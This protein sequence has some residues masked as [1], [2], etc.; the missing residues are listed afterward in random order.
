MDTAVGGQGAPLVP[1][2]DYLRYS[3]PEKSRIILNLGGIAN[4]TYLPSSG[5][6]NEVRAFDVGPANILIDGAVRELY[7]GR[8]TR[9]EG[10]A[11]ARKGQ[12]SQA[13]FEYILKLDD[14]RFLPFPKSTGRERYSKSFLN[15]V[16]DHG[17]KKLRL[18]R[19]DIIATISNYS[20]FMIEYHV[21]KILKDPKNQKVELIVGGGGSKN[22]FLIEGLRGMEQF[23][24]VSTHD[25]YGV[26]ARFWEC[27]SFGIL[28]YL[29]YYR[30]SGNVPSATGASRS[31]VLGR[32]NYPV[33]HQID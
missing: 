16:L 26:P 9:D 5:G 30:V 19:E 10:G 33:E 7:S 23:G 8:K 14:F 18:P 12:L 29:A 15:K 13:L 1:M 20:L 4:F 3:D 27:F 11:L 6:L 31:V 32:I 21:K 22:K 25:V 24:K 17:N 2:V 28:A